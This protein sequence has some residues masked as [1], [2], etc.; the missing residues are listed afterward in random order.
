M[1]A[2]DLFVLA[3]R[4]AADGD[5]EG[6]PVVLMEAMALRVPVVSTFHSGI[7]ELIE[8]GRTGRLV[9]EGD[10]AA[11]AEI[12]RDFAIDPTPFRRL[13][14]PAHDLVARDFSAKKHI[15][16]LIEAIRGERRHRGRSRSRPGACLNETLLE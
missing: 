10:D 2:S 5:M 4:T 3:S 9:P 1:R 7:P 16:D 14:D 13:V 6:L 15:A 8:D 12:L 11:L